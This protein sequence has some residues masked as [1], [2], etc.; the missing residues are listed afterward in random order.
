MTAVARHIRFLF[1]C[2][3][4]AVLV[5]GTAVDVWARLRERAEFDRLEKRYGSLDGR[6]IVA[7]SVAPAENSARFVRAAAALTVRPRSNAG[8]DTLGRAAT[9]FEELLDSSSVPEDV[10][11]W[12]DANDEAIRLAREAVTRHQASWDAD[13][14][15]DANTPRPR[16]I[17]T[18]ASALYLATILDLKAGHVDEASR[19]TTAGLAV[20]ASLRYEPSLALQLIRTAVA[21]QQCQ[22][23][24]RLLARSAPSK[25]ALGDLAR[26]LAD[27][28]QTD[29]MRVALRAELRFMNAKL[30]NAE[31]GPL[32]RTSRLEYL[33]QMERLIDTQ[34][35]PRPRP[36]VPVWS[37]SWL[38]DPRHVA[39]ILIPSL[40]R[41]LDDAD[42]YNNV[43]A[44]AEIGVAAR[45]F[46]ED[47]GSYPDDLP[48]LAPVYLAHLPIDAV[49]GA[50]PFYT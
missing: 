12:R 10:R 9:R 24:E 29:P 36:R 22:A 33:R 45:R 14:A 8:Y 40:E 37:D 6:S 7:P 50:P 44:V 27:N 21:M 49:T 39:S 30:V 26:A 28:R 19:D 3:V 17:A 42:T 41:A 35:G 5:I 34:S 46:R 25:A 18:L 23:A 2:C 1:L 4:V 11:A 13:Y 20:A 31:S 15:S 38:R 32:D 43:L 48:A 47:R 16:D